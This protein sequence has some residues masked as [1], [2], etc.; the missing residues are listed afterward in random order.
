MVRY[1]KY[2]NAFTFI[3]S[4]RP[5]TPASR[6]HDSIDMETKRKRL[7]KLNKTWNDLALE[8]NKAYVGRT[9]TV[10]VDGLSKKKYS[11]WR[12]CRS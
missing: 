6:M 4:A 11:A 1:C 8:K 5:G 3:F 10:L 2:D 7:A 12:F 9:V